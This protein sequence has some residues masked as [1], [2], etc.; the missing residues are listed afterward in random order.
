MSRQASPRFSFIKRL[1]DELGFPALASL[2]AHAVRE[3]PVPPRLLAALLRPDPPGSELLTE[4][5]REV[6]VL[7]ASGFSRQEIADVLRVDYETVKS[8]L[9]KTYAI[10]GAH[11]Q[12]Q[13]INAF[14]EKAA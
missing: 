11:N 14:L 10:L 6:M 13:A 12:V 7:L 1:A 8:H 4:R 3:R 5:Q 2:E 9:R